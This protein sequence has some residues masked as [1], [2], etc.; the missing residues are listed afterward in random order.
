MDPDTVPVAPAAARN[1]P[2]DAPSA[3]FGAKLPVVAKYRPERLRL[4]VFDALPKEL[5]ADSSPLTKLTFPVKVLAPVKAKSPV[6]A[7]PVAVRFP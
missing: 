5:A 3:M 7:P 6:S 2:P 1:I 4:R